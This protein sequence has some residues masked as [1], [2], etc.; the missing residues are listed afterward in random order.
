M[1][2]IKRFFKANLVSIDRKKS[3]LIVNDVIW[4]VFEEKYL[5]IFV[6]LF[7]PRLVFKF[8]LTCFIFWECKINAGYDSSCV[9]KELPSHFDF[10]VCIGKQRRKLLKNLH[11]KTDTC[12]HYNQRIYLW[13]FCVIFLLF[14]SY[15]W[16]SSLW[17][18]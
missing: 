5:H 18:I 15:F 6:S 7:C 16:P 2:K 1:L 12:I 14:F 4:V 17:A 9:L 10:N 8:S 11:G 13:S 3:S